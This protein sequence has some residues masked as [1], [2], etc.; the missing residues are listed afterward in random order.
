MSE[1]RLELIAAVLLSIATV[2]TA[3][4]AYQAR[5]WTGQQAIETS[6]ATAARIQSNRAAAVA[7]RQ[8]QIDVATFI[9]WIDAQQADKPELARFY[10]ERF[11]DEFRPAFGSWL[12]TR[13]LEDPSAPATP[14]AM[15][16]YRLKANADAERLE[17]RAEAASARSQAANERAGNSMLAVVLFAASLFFAGISTK[18]HDPRVRH[19]MLGMGLLVLLGTLV[20][21]ATVPVQWGS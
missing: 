17:A 18:L 14:F 11:R 20:W 12:A 1:R 6:R 8:T 13:P 3:W 16:E 19:A 5:Q 2:A 7:D 4:S 21:I 15:P 10:R 9:Q